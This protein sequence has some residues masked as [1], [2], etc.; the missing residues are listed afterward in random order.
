MIYLG[1]FLLFL[2]FSSLSTVE[3]QSFYGKTLVPTSGCISWRTIRIFLLGDLVVINV[4]NRIRP[5]IKQLQIKLLLYTCQSLL[6]IFFQSR[7]M[8]SKFGGLVDTSR[9]IC[10]IFCSCKKKLVIENETYRRNTI[11]MKAA[12][13]PLDKSNLNWHLQEVMNKFKQ[14]QAKD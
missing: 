1:T 8:G 3:F 4:V 9:T 14:N 13:E 11:I 10:I 6:F 2:Y 7:L 5:F 12:T